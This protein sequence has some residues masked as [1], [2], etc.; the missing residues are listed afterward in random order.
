MSDLYIGLMSGTSMDAID[1]ALVRFGDRTAEILATC[2]HPYP[3]DVRKS[4]AGAKLLENIRHAGDVASLHRRV[5]ECFRD[6]ARLLLRQAGI[7]AAK[8]AAIG[9]HGQTLR[10]E[11]DA[12]DPFSLQIGD[13][14]VI[15]RGT[16]IVTVAD[17][18]SAD[19][20]HGGQGAPLTPAFHEWLFR[21]P[22]VT[23]IVI[24]IG[25]I[26]NLTLLP[27]RGGVVTGYDTG[28]GNTLLDAWVL[29][30][31][32]QPFDR[33]GLWAAQGIVNQALLGRL[34]ADPYFSRSPPKSTGFEYFNL[35][36]LERHDIS[37]IDARDV[38]ATLC[39]LTALSV[40]SEVRAAATAC[41]VL[42]CG[43]GAHNAELMRRLANELRGYA[44]KTTA[45]AGLEPDWVEAAA[46]AWLAMRRL[47]NLTG[48]LPTVTGAREAV[49]LGRIHAPV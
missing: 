49:L 7:D 33:G 23:R 20:S 5:G 35:G 28:P 41:D 43:G 1:A 24:N 12:N 18:R 2:A 4:L 9:S 42:I 3:A 40:G 6:A 17:F 19:I 37:G 8:V 36:W 16:G 31:R 34:L 13:A 30:N 45:V 26:A 44:I 32:G 25:G 39:A 27:V 22:D 29:S 38:Q 47:N 15:A 48:N 21:K 14:D 46:F 11:P 10:H